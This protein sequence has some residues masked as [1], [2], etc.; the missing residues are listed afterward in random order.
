MLKLKHDW[1]G[2]EDD[3]DY[4][5]DQIDVGVIILKKEELAQSYVYGI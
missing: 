3:E 2:Q 5:P 4:E 1:K